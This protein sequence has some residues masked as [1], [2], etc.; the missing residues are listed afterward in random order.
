MG[1]LVVA[2]DRFISFEDGVT[3]DLE[4]VNRIRVYFR[5]ISNGRLVE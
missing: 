5:R 2:D 4:E 1:C 3:S